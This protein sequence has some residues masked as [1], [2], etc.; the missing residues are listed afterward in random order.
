MIF[1]G[2]FAVSLFFDLNEKILTKI[3]NTASIYDIFIIKKQY[4][5][6]LILFDYK[7]DVDKNFAEQGGG[8]RNHDGFRE[9][10]RSYAGFYTADVKGFYQRIVLITVKG[11]FA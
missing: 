7:T 5:K 2:D 1:Q 8:R 11:E 4:F 9:R 10:Q 6:F 3:L